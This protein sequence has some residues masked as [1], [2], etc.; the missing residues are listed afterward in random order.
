[1]TQ[2]ARRTFLITSALGGGALL[3]GCMEAAAPTV[4]AVSVQGRAGMNPGPSGGDRP[5]TLT[6]V[7]LASSSAFDSADYFALQDPAS[8]LGPDLIR[9]NQI[10]LA[11]GGTATTN[12]TIQPGTTVVG[13]IGGFR[14]PGGRTVR[15]KIPAPAANSGLIIN[16]GAGGLALTRA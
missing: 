5:V 16:V 12:I 13:V 9:T 15:S 14:S 6:I 11:P 4:L 2:F 8:A 7:Q 3:A 10:V 1:M